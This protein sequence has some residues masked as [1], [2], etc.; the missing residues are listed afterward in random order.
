MNLL[1]DYTTEITNV[2]KD[3]F[4]T[5]KRQEPLTFYK[6]AEEQILILDSDFNAD[7]QEYESENKVLV[8]QSQQFYCRIIFPKRESVF[9]TSIPNT[10]IPIKGEQDFSEVYI[11]MEEDAYLFCKDAIRFTFMGENYEKL[12]PIRKIGFADTFNVYQLYLK[13][14]V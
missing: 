1:S 8:E 7:I 9:H 14:V 3:I 10:S 11:Q 4:D 13:R 12:S 5:F 6:T 2:M